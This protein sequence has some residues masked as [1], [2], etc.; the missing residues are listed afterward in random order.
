MARVL[1]FGDHTPR[2]QLSI[3]I[4]NVAALPDGRACVSANRGAGPGDGS[5]AG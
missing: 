2:W 4:N 1:F 3:G 5:E